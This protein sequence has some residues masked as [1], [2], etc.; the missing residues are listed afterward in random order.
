MNTVAFTSWFAFPCS[1]PRLT[2]DP[3]IHT[4]DFLG[5]EKVCSAYGARG[6]EDGVA[7][8]VGWD[9]VS[10]PGGWRRFVSS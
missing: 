6:S 10:A 8:K 1:S 5:M 2:W 4:L 7:F 9:K 3:G